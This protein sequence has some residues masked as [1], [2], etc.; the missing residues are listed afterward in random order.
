MF[1][2]HPSRGSAVVSNFH[3]SQPR[4]FH[5]SN[6]LIRNTVRILFYLYHIMLHF[7]YVP[8]S[9]KFENFAKLIIPQLIAAIPSEHR[10]ASSM[11]EDVASQ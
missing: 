11:F 8:L 3:A 2:S 6:S 4:Q 1:L 5:F 9:A 7:S 10:L